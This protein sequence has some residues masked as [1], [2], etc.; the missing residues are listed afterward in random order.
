MET[1]D[2]KTQLENQIEIEKMTIPL[3]LPEVSIRK[4][5][6][7]LEN[8]EF[9]KGIKAAEPEKKGETQ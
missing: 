8:D 7:A 2:P 1:V 5:L 3:P 9:L 6:V 4:K